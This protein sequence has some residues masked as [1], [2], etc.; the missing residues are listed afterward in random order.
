M[1]RLRH[2]RHV[3]VSIRLSQLR[4]PLTGQRDQITDAVTDLAIDGDAAA[5]P[6][7]D[8]AKPTKA[9]GR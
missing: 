2:H 3:V 7:N 8:A 5:M 1:A 4:H 9:P 6:L